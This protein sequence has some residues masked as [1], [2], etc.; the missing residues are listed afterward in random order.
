MELLYKHSDSTLRY[1]VTRNIICEFTVA[2]NPNHL[3]IPI[4]MYSHIY[5]YTNITM[6]RDST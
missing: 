2:S 6:G 3:P 1:G 5:V 4:A